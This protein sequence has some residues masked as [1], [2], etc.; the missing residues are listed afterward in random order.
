M[1]GDWRKLRLNDRVR[2]VHL[3]TEFSQPGYFVHRDTLRVYRRRIDRGR[4]VRVFKIDE[5]KIPWV[6]FQFRRKDGRIEYYSLAI[7]H[8]GWVRVQRRF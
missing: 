7:N 8:D 1:D 5:W 4:S 6:Q 3:P 2:L